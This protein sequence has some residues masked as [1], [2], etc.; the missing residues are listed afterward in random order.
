MVPFGLGWNKARRPGA[1]W[2]AEAGVSPPGPWPSAP[3]FPL[4]RSQSKFH[5]LWSR[6]ARDCGHCWVRPRSYSLELE[7]S[8]EP[9]LKFPSWT[10]GLVSSTFE[11]VLQG[12]QTPTWD[13]SSFHGETDLGYN[14]S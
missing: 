3:A 11:V 10:T 9:F 7:G 1:L 4:E 5:S 14:L 13:P 12:L 6:A 8:L 2:G